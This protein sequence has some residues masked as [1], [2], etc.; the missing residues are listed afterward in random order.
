M[1]TKDDEFEVIELSMLDKRKFYPLSGLGSFTVHSMLYP[2]VLLRIRLQLQEGA[3]LY[4][5]L[6]H[7]TSCI[8]REEGFRGLYSGYFVKSAQI[9]SSVFYASTYETVRHMSSGIP[10]LSQTQ[11]S[12]I[13]GGVA[14][15][16]LQ[17]V[18]VPVDVI[19]QHLMVLSRTSSISPCSSSAPQA[20]APTVKLKAKSSVQSVMTDVR[21]EQVRS[22]SP[23]RLSASELSTS[24]ARFRAVTSY[25]AHK[26]GIRGFYN[27]YVISLFT[28][29]PSSAMWWAFYDKFCRLIAST[30]SKLDD[31]LFASN[32]TNSSGSPLVPR[33][34][35]QLIAAPLAGIASA[36][37]VNPIDC[38][39]VR[40][41]V[42]NLSFRETTRILWAKEGIRWFAKG[43]SARLL[44][45]SV[46]SFWLILIYE[47]VKLFC[48]KNEYRGRFRNPSS[49][50]W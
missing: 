5:G 9:I 14:S 16:L 37:L 25:V 20:I 50:E 10:G 23:I 34:A 38:V 13:G 26:H 19:S 11:R 4:T 22:L 48:L 27:G 8:L 21:L 2:L 47:P 3:H 31:A 43:L 7:A 6:A 44:Q 41:Q 45:T 17:T 36:A 33:L 12:F 24:W 49:S 29:V 42:G 15:M 32:A 30:V 1:T 18:L 40:M 28:F 35:I 39:R 46:F